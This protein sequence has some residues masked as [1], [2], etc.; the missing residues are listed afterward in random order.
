MRIWKSRAIAGAL[1]LL[2][3]S[4]LGCTMLQKTI[5]K[6]KVQLHSVGLKKLENQGLTLLVGLEVENPNAFELR[7]DSLRY[8]AEIE[9]RKVATGMLEDSVGVPAKGKSVVEIP[10]AI[11]YGDLFGSVLDWVTRMGQNEKKTRYRVKGSVRVGLL[12]IPFDEQGEL[13]LEQ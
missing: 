5:E 6:P 1:S 10:V 3:A 2:L 9:G 11:N 7:V 8:E 13:D 12:D 4:A